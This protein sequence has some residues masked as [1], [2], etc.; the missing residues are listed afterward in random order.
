MRLFTHNFLQCHVKGCNS[1]NFPLTFTEAE[2]DKRETEM[3]VDFIKSFLHKIEWN[4][5]Q[6]AVQ[7]VNMM[8]RYAVFKKIL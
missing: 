6:T 3:N 4:A 5:L 1:N 7:Q 8:D 2:L